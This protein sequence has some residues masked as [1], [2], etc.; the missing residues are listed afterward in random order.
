MSLK[1]FCEVPPESKDARIARLERELEAANTRISEACS[2]ERQRCIDA[3][4]TTWLDPLLSGDNGIHVPASCPDIERLLLALR[5][6]MEA[7]K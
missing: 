1:P 7:P 6:R 3:I 5:K 4:P 2:T